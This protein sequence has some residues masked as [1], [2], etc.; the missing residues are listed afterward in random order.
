MERNEKKERLS[1][2]RKYKD[3]E[4]MYRWNIDEKKCID[5]KKRFD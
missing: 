1:E 5:E 2:K 4:K 3:V